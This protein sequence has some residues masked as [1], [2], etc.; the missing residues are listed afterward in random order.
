MPT[1]PRPSRAAI[2]ATV[3]PIVLANASTPLL[4]LADTAVIGRR[5]SVEELGAIALGA[6]VFSFVFWAFGF[7]RMAT[8][9]FV[10]QAD[11]AG[12][13]PGLRLAVL[14]PLVIGGLIGVALVA[15]QRPIE[16]LALALLDGTPAV[17][18]VT[19][20]YIR[21]R[22]WGAPAALATYALTGTLIALRLSR[23]LLALQLVVNGLNIALDVWLAGHLDLGARGVAIG[24]AVA[25]WSGLACALV[26]VGAALRRRHADAA[27]FVPWR[28]LLDRAGLGGMIGAQLD[29]MARTLLLLGG[30]G[31]FTNQGARFGDAVLGANHLLLQLIS[32]S[33]FVLDG[34]A[35]ATEALVGAAKG[36]GDRGAFD[37]ALRRTTELAVAAAILL[38]LALAA[39]GPLAVDALTDLPVVRSHAKTWLPHV[40]AYVAVSVF[41]F[42]LDG[43]FIGAT[44]TRAMRNA[45][46]AA[47]LCFL[48]LSWVLVPAS[49]NHGL[50]LAFIGYVIARGISLAALTP[51]LRRDIGRAAEGG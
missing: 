9:G 33:A 36:A 31:W 22:I 15:L 25:E 8:T 27:P 10:A 13:E 28:R 26:M 35:F 37:H 40:I 24:T 43:V 12:D 46:L 32:F 44:R 48:A 34:F 11:G 4:G 16:A 19:A 21:A 5:G 39:F 6:L 45:A 23:R 49:G 42:Q 2:L 17:E 1:A 41:A 38:A 3:W 30:F 50:W 20:E 18:A 14:R 7:L 51:A 47:L 29:I